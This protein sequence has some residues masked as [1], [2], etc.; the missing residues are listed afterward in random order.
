M[1]INRTLASIARLL[2]MFMMFALIAA[3]CGRGPEN[4]PDSKTNSEYVQNEPVKLLFAQKWSE[5]T[6]EEFQQLIVEPLQRK[7]PNLSIEVLGSDNVANLIAG[8]QTPD[9]IATYHGLLPDYQELD[10]LDDMTP[11]IKKYGVDLN[12]F[13]QAYL[14]TIRT[15]GNGGLVALP[16]DVNFEVIYYNKDIFDKFGVAYPKDGMT[17][18]ETVDLAKKLARMDGAVQYR[19]LE[20]D[21]YGRLAMQ[22]AL[23]S[24]KD[25]KAYVNNDQWKRIF[26]L[27][28][29]I[30]TIPGNEQLT[31]D[32]Y[33]HYRDQFLKNKNLAMLAAG[34]MFN[35]LQN[36]QGINWDL[37]QYPSYPDDPNSL[38]MVDE[39]VIFVTKTSKYKDAAFQVVKLFTS[40]E[41]QKMMTSR[42]G[43][44]TVLKD[45]AVKQQMGKEMPVLNGK[46]IDAILKGH[47]IPA[48]KPEKYQSAADKYVSEAFDSYLGGAQ[49]LN[50]S[51][52]TA[53]EKINLM[54]AAEQSK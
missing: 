29:T 32:R 40:D 7:Y 31:G 8:G 33:V 30:Y 54:I 28:K 38:G 10:L 15:F 25:G 11:L 4:P 44:L 48:Y 23:P 2:A 17:W 9:L 47:H 24:V 18:T 5:I 20:P 51:L 21:G 41:V 3:G 37:A 52:R 12:R 46:N 26:E 42:S 19:G 34:Y 6:N 36:A 22:L 14:D 16:Y 35:L 39:H 27:A 50:T 13:E 45:P 53:E 43:K 49:D 1:R